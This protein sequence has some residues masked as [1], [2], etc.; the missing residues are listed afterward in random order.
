MAEQVDYKSLYEASERAREAAERALKEKDR[1]LKDAE[2]QLAKTSFYDFLEICHTNIFLKLDIEKN[3]LKRTSGGLTRVDGKL[4]PRDLKPW[5]DFD[6]RLEASFALLEANFQQESLF[7]SPAGLGYL[8]DKLRDKRL[9]SEEDLK[10]FECLAVEGCTLDV[11]PRFIGRLN[12][13]TSGDGGGSG[14]GSGSSSSR[15]R[16]AIVDANTL[17]SVSFYNYPFGV[18]AAAEDEQ[19]SEDGGGGGGDSSS[20]V[21]G[22]SGSTDITERSV[23]RSQS[24]GRTRTRKP[25]RIKD[26]LPAYIGAL[27]VAKRDM[28]AA[29]ERA[30]AEAEER[31]RSGPP[32]KRLS[33]E[34][35]KVHPDQWCF[36]NSTDGTMRPLFVIEYK[37][38]HKISLATLRHAL[39]PATAATLVRDA[40]AVIAGNKNEEGGISETTVE[41]RDIAKIFAQTFHYMVD[42]GLQYCYATTG[43]A[44]I[45]LFLDPEQPS[46]LF[47][48]LEEP[49]QSVQTTSRE[50]LRHS[51]VGLVTSFVLMSLQGQ[52]MTN[53]W[54]K[55]L[56]KTLP[57]WPQP[58]DDMGVVASATLGMVPSLGPVVPVV[59]AGGGA[60][61]GDPR[62]PDGSRRRDQDHDGSCDDVGNTASGSRGA[63]TSTR[64]PAVTATAS[65][66]TTAST[67]A[68]ETASET[69]KHD[70]QRAVTWAWWRPVDA[71]LTPSLDYCTQACLLGL[72][73][74]GPKD[75]HC[76]N[77]HRHRRH[78]QDNGSDTGPHPITAEELRDLLVLQLAEDLDTDCQSLERFGMYGAI[79]ALFKLALSVYG[80]CFVG[81]GVQRVHR[82]VLQREAATYGLLEACQGHLVPVNLGVIELVDEYW[83][84]CGAHISHMMLMAYAGESLWHCRRDASRAGAGADVMSRYRAAGEQTLA[85]LRQYGVEHGDEDDNNLV[86]NTELQRVM[87]V[88][89][90]YAEL[91]EPAPGTAVVAGGQPGHRRKASD[92][93]CDAQDAKRVRILRETDVGAF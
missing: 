20:N 46:T 14:S 54:K 7:P 82:K 73:T 34:R 69:T 76:P 11:L 66:T 45:F 79:G 93:L 2:K 39:E 52:Y 37:A 89:F 65:G 21:D 88:D 92:E 10:N 8:E 57:K 56:H 26:N 90:D 13:S 4:Y 74:G 41:Y 23:S 50:R 36:R 55:T 85:E 64:A 51:A 9:A 71:P 42:Y 44:L 68:T 78:G 29:A 77:V 53:R 59:S 61:C 38:A 67:T 84:E 30:A 49:A 28:D 25:L 15:K 1:A 40:I 86:W 32:R 63:S 5:S 19:E 33:P 27:G 70:M 72:K 60:R 35:T 62:N 81:K 6:S 43:H 58:Y 75:A 83:T 91:L 17:Q 48:H 12:G 31:E 24:R 18:V 87:A 22:T 47:Y 80:Y 3:E 16:P